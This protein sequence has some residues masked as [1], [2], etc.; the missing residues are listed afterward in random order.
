MAGNESAKNQGRV[1]ETVGLIFRREVARE[2]RSVSL[3]DK[4]GRRN[5]LDNRDAPNKNCR[6]VSNGSYLGTDCL[7]QSLLITQSSSTPLAMNT[8]SSV[9]ACAMRP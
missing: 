2:K 9:T 6:E 5:G 7:P 1:A 8:I 3:E 4:R